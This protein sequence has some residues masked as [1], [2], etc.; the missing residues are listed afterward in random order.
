MLRHIA[1]EMGSLV[2]EK[3]VGAALTT[4]I[5]SRFVVAGGINTHFL[6]AGSGFPVVLLHS[7]EFG[8]CAGCIACAAGWQATV[9]RA[10]RSARLDM[11]CGAGQP[12][13]RCPQH[14]EYFIRRDWGLRRRV[15]EGATLCGR[16]SSG[17]VRV[18]AVWFGKAGLR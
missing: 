3:P 7:G 5:H 18:P 8:G 13:W 12:A 4:G 10:R 16:P 11:R 9:T 1:N 6:E 14:V 17:G 2:E 15:G